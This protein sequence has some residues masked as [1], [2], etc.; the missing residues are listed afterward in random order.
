MAGA[1][2]GVVGGDELGVIIWIFFGFF[3]LEVLVKLKLFPLCS[4]VCLFQRLPYPSAC[5]CIQINCW[6]VFVDS[7]LHWKEETEN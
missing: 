6:L 2:T 4:I 3:R 5:F 7:L 1:D